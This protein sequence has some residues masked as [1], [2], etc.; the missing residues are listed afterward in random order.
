ME[1]G[2][3]M[4]IL[5]IEDEPQVAEMLRSALSHLG[6]S[7]CLA[8][9]AEEADRLLQQQE[10]D[11]VTLD[12]GMPGRGGLDWLESIAADRPDLARKTIVITGVDL[13]PIEIKRLAQCGAGM[14][15]KPFTL[16]SL[17]EAI[18]TQID[19][20]TGTCCPAD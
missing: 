8:H 4:K 20:P 18:R 11:C 9:S 6:L 3:S 17:S 2:V 7:P 10:I 5:V 19:R 1:L 14:L 15:A 16:D 12:L 13:E